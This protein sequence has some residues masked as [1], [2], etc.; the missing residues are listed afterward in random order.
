MNSCRIFRPA[1]GCCTL[2]TLV[3]IVIFSVFAAK[4]L[5]KQEKE[6]AHFFG[7]KT[8]DQR[9]GANLKKTV[10]CRNLLQISCFFKAFL[11]QKCWKWLFRP[12]FGV[13]STQTLVEIYNQTALI[14]C[15]NIDVLTMC[16]KFH[17]DLM[18]Q[19]KQYSEIWNENISL[20]TVS[21]VRNILKW[22]GMIVY[23]ES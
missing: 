12:S 1:F 7:N 6:K 11:Q 21:V 10:F 22:N 2:Q 17:L 8:V 15:I 4:K 13:C 20:L 16:N 3:E 14:S 19:H 5:K 18:I 9:S 23:S